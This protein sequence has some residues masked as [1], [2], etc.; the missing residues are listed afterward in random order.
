VRYE[1]KL[2]TATV[3]FQKQPKNTQWVQTLDETR[4]VTMNR[5]LRIL[6]KKREERELLKRRAVKEI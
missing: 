6:Q 5:F 2:L 4:E 3:Y 1:V